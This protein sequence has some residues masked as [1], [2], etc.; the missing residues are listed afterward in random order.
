MFCILFTLPSPT[1]DWASN[2]FRRATALPWSN[3]THVS[4]LFTGICT[5]SGANMHQALPA[6]SLFT[7]TTSVPMWMDP[8]Q[9][10]ISRLIPWLQ[11]TLVIHTCG[12]TLDL[13]TAWDYIPQSCPPKS[14]F[15][16]HPPF[17]PASWP[18]Y[19]PMAALWGRS[20]FPWVL[21]L[22]PSLHQLLP[23]LSFQARIHDP[24]LPQIPSPFLLLL[25]LLVKP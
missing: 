16:I 4:G 23:F 6:G 12:Q 2:L 11:V 5:T 3:E 15:L 9:I 17:L 19:Y 1:I 21:L 20:L 25:D 13:V 14:Y 7:L 22:L 18:F 10:L 8:H 24:S